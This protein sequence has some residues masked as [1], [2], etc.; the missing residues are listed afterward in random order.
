M[1]VEVADLIE[2]EHS[3]FGRAYQTFAADLG[4]REGAAPVAEQLA[5]GQVRID[6]AAIQRDEWPMAALLVE[7]V[8][9][10]DKHFLA[11]PR[12]ARDQR[13][14]VAERRDPHDPAED[15]EHLA[16]PTDHAQLLHH[17]PNLLVLD[18][19][20]SLRAH[21]PRERARE[22]AWEFRRRAVEYVEGAGQQELATTA[23]R[24]QT[25]AVTITDDD[26]SDASERADLS[27]ERGA[28]LRAFVQGDQNDAARLRLPS[29][30]RRKTSGVV[31]LRP[32]LLDHARNRFQ[33]RATALTQQPDRG[34]GAIL[35]R[36]VARLFQGCQS[37]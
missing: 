20:V 19:P 34:R 2:E 17:A 14:Q 21:E 6:G 33:A 29:S 36:A 28:R 15:G 22:L 5:L 25:D 37:L 31:Q 3:A 18:A 11:R 24:P 23:E 16:A 8:Q 27:R 32:A 1:W 4:S 26:A 9:R 35:P 13:R 12:L 30:S 10:V 7:A